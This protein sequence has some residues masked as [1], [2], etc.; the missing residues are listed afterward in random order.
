M[1]TIRVGSRE[2]RLAVVQS[3]L[4]MDAIRA[5]HPEVG[6]ELVTMKTTGDKILDR[7]LDKVGG[8]GLF[9]K[10]LDAALLDGRVDLTVHSCKD[11]PMEEDPRIPLAGFSRREDPRD[12][13]VLPQGA[14]ELDPSRPI[15][16]ASARRAV[17]LRALFPG[18]AVAP[19]RGNVLTRLRKLDEGQFSALVLAAAGLKRLGLEERITRYFTVEELLPAAGQG[20][21]ALQTRAGEELSCLDGVLDA[22]GTDC[23]RTERAF[24]RALDGGCSAPTAAHARL[25][26]DTVTIDGLY[27]TDA[28]EVRRGRLSGPPAQGEALGEAL[29]RRLKEGGTCLEK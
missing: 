22:D 3:E 9:V 20:I 7:T 21:L 16:C 27:V 1:K 28:G 23:A 17:Q 13:L 15:G 5:A 18:V 14:E 10:E 29:A 8:K 24:V 4:V 12:V 11:L 6:L 2:S 26:G 25:E 19:V